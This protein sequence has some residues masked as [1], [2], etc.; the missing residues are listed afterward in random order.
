M[1]LADRSLW[2]RAFAYKFVWKHEEI[3]LMILTMY[4]IVKYVKNWCT[5]TWV[6]KEHPG[7]KTVFSSRTWYKKKWRTGT[8][9]FCGLGG[10]SNCLFYG[11]TASLPCIYDSRICQGR[12]TS[13]FWHRTDAPI[14]CTG[15]TRSWDV[16]QK[17]SHSS[18]WSDPK[19]RHLQGGKNTY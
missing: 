16:L 11:P 14:C 2:V 6:L 9:S 8:L 15:C 3:P 18:K 1:Q 19:S 13:W 12:W 4:M 7:S 17:V 5:K 10:F